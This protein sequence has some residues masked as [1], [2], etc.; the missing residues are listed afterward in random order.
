MDMRYAA[1]FSL[2]TMPYRYMCSVLFCLY[3][4]THGHLVDR[5]SGI[6]WKTC[7]LLRLVALF[8]STKNAIKP[9]ELGTPDSHN[10]PTTPLLSPLKMY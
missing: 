5:V 4:Y 8:V 9:K 7:F 2:V 1:K 10:V 3:Q 6:F